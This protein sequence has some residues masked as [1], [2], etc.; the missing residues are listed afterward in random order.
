MCFPDVKV[1]KSTEV[2]TVNYCNAELGF[3]SLWC[4]ER[5]YKIKI[6][7]ASLACEKFHGEVPAAVAPD[8]LHAFEVALPGPDPG[9]GAGGRVRVRVR[10]ALHRYQLDLRFP[11]G[12]SHS[13]TT[14]RENALLLLGVDGAGDIALAEA[15]LPPKCDH[16]YCSDLEDCVV[17]VRAWE[18]RLRELALEPSARGGDASASDPLQGLPSAAAAPLRARLSGGD[19]RAHI[20]RNTLEALDT[21]APVVEDRAFASAS[22]AMVEVAILSMLTQMPRPASSSANATVHGLLGLDPALAQNALTFY[23]VGLNDDISIMLES[24]RFGREFTPHVK[25]KLDADGRKRVLDALNLWCSDAETKEG[26]SRRT[27]KI[28]GGCQLRVD[29][30]DRYGNVGARAAPAQTAHLHGGAA[31]PRRADGVPYR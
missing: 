29:T 4:G 30:R 21:C 16:V 3:G 28:L 10:V 18:R 31:V 24:A 25:I 9:G 12:T 22:Q 26:I 2:S 1:Y 17:V 19:T 27:S 11:F 20:L 7:M 5:D 14:Q 6:K 23:T 13:S 15:G 8:P